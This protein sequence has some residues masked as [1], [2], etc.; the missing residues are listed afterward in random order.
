[1]TMFSRLIER[2]CGEHSRRRTTEWRTRL[3][4]FEHKGQAFLAM[5]TRCLLD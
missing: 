1:M 5:G 2:L 4:G 3:V